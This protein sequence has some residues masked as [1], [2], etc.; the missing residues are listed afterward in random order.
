APSLDRRRR[1]CALA[2]AA[3]VSLPLSAA[4]Q[5]GPQHRET[6]SREHVSVKLSYTLLDGAERCP[7]VGFLRREASARL[8]YDPFDNPEPDA[9]AIGSVRVTIARPLDAEHPRR[10]RDELIATTVLDDIQGK[11]RWSEDYQVDGTTRSACEVAIGGVVRM[12]LWDLTVP[13]AS[14]PAP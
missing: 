5:S 11:A 4:A 10:R 7:A 1:A 6:A 2:G 14:A 9:R 8:G 13:P 3:L 12:L